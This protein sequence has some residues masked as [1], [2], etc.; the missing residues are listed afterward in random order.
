[1]PVIYATI[2]TQG[3]NLGPHPSFSP[4]KEEE[5]IREKTGKKTTQMPSSQGHKYLL[6]FIDTFTRW[7]ETF[8]TRTERAQEVIKALLKEINPQF[9]LPRSLQSD[10][11]PSFV[12]KVTQH[13]STA[14]GI[15]YHLHAAWRPQ[16]S[17]K[18]ERANQTLKRILA[19]LCQETSEPWT[20]L[21]PVA[22]LRIRVAPKTGIKLSPFEMTYGRP[23]L[24]FDILVDTENS[25]LIKYLIKLGLVQKAIAEY[26]NQVL[27]A[28]SQKTGPIQVRPGDVSSEN[29]EGSVPL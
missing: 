18:V 6:V 23:F 17:G 28:S 4:S 7:G 14:L 3:E 15:C 5:L 2:T 27:L 1:M 21:L 26:G 10:N 19:K 25:V 29:M 24:S 13:I 20:K 11:G 12:A 22:L 8:P 16:S 9:G